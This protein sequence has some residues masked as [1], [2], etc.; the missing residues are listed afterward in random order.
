M[1][2]AKAASKGAFA[3]A[4][5]LHETNSFSP[6][7]TDLAAFAKPSGAWLRGGEEMAGRLSSNFPV[8]GFAVGAESAGFTP[9]PVTDVFAAP[10]GTITADAYLAIRGE[11][12]E[13]LLAIEDAR[14]LLLSLHGAAV[15]D[16][17]LDPEGEIVARLRRARPDA[18]LGVVLDHHAG[19]SEALV[20]SSDVVIGYKT[21]PHVDTADCGAKAAAVAA[22]ILA[23]EIT[24]IERWFV[25]LPLLLPIEN[26]L[27]TH[28]PLETL[29]ERAGSFAERAEVVD[30]SLFPGFSYSDKPAT[31]VSVLVQTDG[32]GELAR[33]IAIELAQDWWECREEFWIPVAEPA[34]AVGLA[35]GSA[36]TPVALVDKAD[37]PGAGSVGDGSLLLRLL[38]ERG[39][40]STVVAPIHDPGSVARAMEVGVGNTGRFGIG[41]VLT[42]KPFETEARVRL[43]SDGAY[44][45]LG[46][47]E[48]GAQLTIGRTA[49]LEIGE[50]EA[51]VCE[52][53]SGLYD[54]EI[55]R[56]V[57][58]EPTR[59]RILCM[60][61]LG[62]FRAA[63]EEILGEV[64]LV[65]GEG[66]APQRLEA[67]GYQHVRRPA[68]PLDRDLSFDAATA[69]VRIPW[70]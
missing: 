46:P 45:A 24:S 23:G 41:G 53:R 44:E 35:L 10:S 63:F 32:D 47:F 64:V 37:H 38:C 70:R 55:L 15:A 3:F 30:I 5:F 42:G 68:Y 36:R 66:A 39:A 65:D 1:R 59:R 11:L 49:V 54:P 40:T 21:E 8:H 57:G 62:T 25:R 19:V 9:V 14:G 4:E 51:V 34:E 22:R 29:M 13:G 33:R 48:R 18:A 67:L 26:L 31:G 12:V 6:L 52:G 69:A 16:G 20:A 27:T 28:G 58:I 56:R 43:L 50:V 60:K 61:N 7:K 17:C 2:M